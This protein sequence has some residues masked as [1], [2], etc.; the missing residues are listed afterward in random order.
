MIHDHTKGLMIGKGDQISNLYVLDAH[1]IIPPYNL[2]I[3]YSTKR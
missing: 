2:Q 1:S 3:S